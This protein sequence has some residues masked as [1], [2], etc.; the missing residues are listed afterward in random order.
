MFQESGVLRLGGDEADS[1]DIVD[2]N[3][4]RA[5]SPC[6][7]TFVGDNVVLA[8]SSLS[9]KPKTKKVKRVFHK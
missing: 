1:S 9:S 4:G 8:K 2:N 7:V 3:E 5:V 6:P